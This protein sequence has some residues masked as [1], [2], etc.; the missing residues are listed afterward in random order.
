M[1]L[2]RRAPHKVS[3]LLAL[4]SEDSSYLTLRA[5][6]NYEACMIEYYFPYSP[7]PGLAAC[8]TPTPRTVTEWKATENM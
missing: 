3:C 8:G 1:T 2:S 7:F 5:F 4:L 6:Y